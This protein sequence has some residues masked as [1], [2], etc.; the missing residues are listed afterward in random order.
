MAAQTWF[1][2]GSCIGLT[3]AKAPLESVA[4]T[5]ERTDWPSVPPVTITLP[6]ASSAEHAPLRALAMD[7]AG[8]HEPSFWEGVALWSAATSAMNAVPTITGIA[9]NV[10]FESL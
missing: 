8:D 1:W 7:A 9:K 6:F 10:L 4:S 3:V 2:R 5:L